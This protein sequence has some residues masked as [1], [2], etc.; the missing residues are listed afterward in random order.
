MP[1][2]RRPGST[3]P[4]GTLSSGT[5][6]WRGPSASAKCAIPGAPIPGESRRPPR[7]TSRGAPP[8]SFPIPTRTPGTPMRSE[9][10]SANRPIAGALRSSS[11]RWRA[12]P[13]GRT[14]TSRTTCSTR[15]RTAR[16]SGGR[17]MRAWTSSEGI[18]GSRPAREG[19][20]PAGPAVRGEERVSL[21]RD[22]LPPRAGTGHLKRWWGGGK[23][24]PPPLH[25]RGKAITYSA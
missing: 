22:Q 1:S 20:E 9:G 24:P 15:R 13:A 10:S 21:P 7:G 11:P 25:S 18:R 12:S 4:S 23:G 2:S 5:A 6:P 14:G 3:I 19:A 17:G 8:W 16:I